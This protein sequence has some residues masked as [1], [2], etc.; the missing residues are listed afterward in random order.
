MANTI[1]NFFGRLPGF[2]WAVV[3]SVDTMLYIEC[4]LMVEY[5]LI[6]MI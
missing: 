3:T 1:K 2:L 5:A 4:L 6:G